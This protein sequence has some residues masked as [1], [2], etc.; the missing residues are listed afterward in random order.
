MK[1]LALLT[2]AAPGAMI[3]GYML[4]TGYL[5]TRIRPVP[6]AFVR[7]E[8]A[9][10]E[11]TPPGTASTAGPLP[12]ASTR[13]R[14]LACDGSTVAGGGLDGGPNLLEKVR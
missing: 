4:L 10:I 1:T 14:Q 5:I 8:Q 7:Q 9:T 2:L 12:S 3:A 11:L 6:I 13:V